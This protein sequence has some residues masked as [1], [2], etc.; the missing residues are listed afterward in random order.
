MDAPDT[1]PTAAAPAPSRTRPASGPPR[2]PPRIP[3]ATYRLQ[4]QPGYGFA[5]AAGAVPYLAR[6]GVSHLHLSP[7][8]DAVPGS[9]HGY[10]VVGHGAVREELGGEAELRRLART[11]HEHGLGVVVDIV[12]NHMAVPT[13]TRL[14]RPLWELLRHGPAS[15]YAHWFDVDWEAGGGRLVLPVLDGPPEEELPRLVPEPGVLRYGERVLPLAPGTDGMGTAA[16]VDAQHYRPVRRDTADSALNYRRFLT[17]REL[18]GLR[19]EHPQVFDAT[20]ATVVRLV[21]DGTVD[22]VRVDHLDGLAEPEAY[23]RRLEHRTGGCWTVVE[24][25]LGDREELPRTWP[26]AGTTGYDALRHVDGVFTDGEGQAELAALHVRLT[27]PAPDAGGEWA[28]TVERAAR[29][30]LAEGLAAE[31]ERLARRAAS[32]CEEAGLPSPAGGALRAALVELLVRLP[33]SRPY[34]V[35]G[36]PPST[37]DAAHLEAAS[38]AARG[39]LPHD[40]A[41]ALGPLRDLALGRLGDGPRRRAFTAG[42]AQL[43]AALRAK[44]VEDR[45]GYR[46]TPLLS[47]CEVG[48]EPGEPAVAPERFHAYCGRLQREWPASGTVLSTHDTK[49]SADVRAAIAVLAECPGRWGEFLGGVSGPLASAPG[50]PSGAARYELP[51]PRLNWVAWQTAFGLGSIV[52]QAPG[53]PTYVQRLTRTLLKSAREAALHTNWAAPDAGYE[54]RLAR[55][56]AHV[57]ERAVHPTGALAALVAELAPHTRANVLGMTL[58]HLTMPGVPELYQGTER[59]YRT[60]V[61]PDNR[62]PVP[63]GMHTLQAL[64]AAEHVLAPVQQRPHPENELAVEK[65]R[66]TTAALRLRARHRDW[67]APGTGGHAP[68]RAEGPAA[69]HCLAFVRGGGALTVATRLSRRLRANGGWRGTRLPLPA[70]RWRHAA[71]DGAPLG[72][73]VP[74]EELLADSPVAL[75]VRA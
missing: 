25:V 45:A 35:P 21:R 39:A 29:E 34:A 31:R 23:L 68:L 61:D 66:L 22:G 57:A 27:G 28:P 19:V 70:G 32:A 10:D 14:N 46:Y 60:L 15:P 71:C 3:S 13:D 30:V 38:G 59:L 49:R 40:G 33:V 42:F 67:F 4:L 47:A 56:A 58:V 26:V 12:P 54:E 17:V 9:R 72:G 37:A 52:P 16:L 1:P 24:K 53:R 51:D 5:E 44:S 48:A 63:P 11:A 7:V 74:L 43:G 2:V 50:D 69:G 8:L 18:I 20:H 6:L 64:G 73:S 65:L 55:L 75:L 41:A 62:D 36:T